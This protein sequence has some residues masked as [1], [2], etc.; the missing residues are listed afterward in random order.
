MIKKASRKSRVYRLVEIK[1]KGMGMVAARDIKR[2]EIIIAESPVLDSSLFSER[3]ALNADEKKALAHLPDERSC[4]WCGPDVTKRRAAQQLKHA[5]LKLGQSDQNRVLNLCDAYMKHSN[6]NKTILGVYA[7]NYMIR[8]DISLGS[9]HSVLFLMVSRFNHSCRPN[10]GWVW[11]EPY[12]RVYVNRDVSKG[13][14][15]CIRYGD[16]YMGQNKRM[17]LLRD[18]FG[19]T[20]I[21]DVCQSIKDDELIE[22]NKTRD[23]IGELVK[24]IS[25]VGGL[26]PIEGLRLVD[27]IMQHL[28]KEK[29][30]TPLALGRYSYDAYRFACAV[31]DIKLAKKCIKNA[32]DNYLIVEGSKSKRSQSLEKYF[33]DPKSHF[34]WGASFGG[35][36]VALKTLTNM[37]G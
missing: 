37:M 18:T 19:F 12:V 27:E 35:S 5:F 14:E 24:L 1:D 7:T 20:C 13:E 9:H 25:Q 3:A 31:G 2:G 11:V 29:L 26:N 32:R 34:S 33:N 22:S 36:F 6:G 28:N 10:L 15:L 8:G 21:C 16:I 4:M 30:D 23:R 17:K